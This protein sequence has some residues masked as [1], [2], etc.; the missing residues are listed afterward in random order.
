MTT[1]YHIQEEN[2]KL[3]SSTQDA[4]DLSHSSAGHVSGELLEDAVG[5]ERRQ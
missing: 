5:A 3:V 2:T 1:D 4:V